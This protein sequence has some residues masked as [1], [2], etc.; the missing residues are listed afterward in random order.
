MSTFAWV[1][2]LIN[3]GAKEEIDYLFRTD[4]FYKD[5]Q[6]DIKEF[7]QP[8]F[9]FNDEI[10]SKKANDLFAYY[11][12][13]LIRE[14][15]LIWSVLEQRISQ[16]F[17]FFT[18]FSKK[19]RRLLFLKEGEIQVLKKVCADK[20]SFSYENDLPFLEVGNIKSIKK[21]LFKDFELEVIAIKKCRKVKGLISLFNTKIM[22]EVSLSDLV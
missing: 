1:V 9:N 22:V 2:C 8:F 6:E 18:T 15:S 17:R 20:N 21:G 5:Y 19:G 12:F 14:D 11:L 16:I 10:E 4:S 7:W 3:K 13:V